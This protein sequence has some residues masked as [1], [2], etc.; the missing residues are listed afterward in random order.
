MVHD[1]SLAMSTLRFASAISTSAASP[2]AFREVVDAITAGLGGQ[3]PDLAA[4]FVSH[5]HGA[6]IEDL[7]P[8]LAKALN[9]RVLIGCTGESIV[10]G[11]RE[12]EDGAALS[13]WAGALPGTTVRP[14]AVAAEAESEATLRFEGM[15]VVRDPAR[16]SILVLADPYTFPAAEF[17]E[18][19]N[20]KLPGVPAIGGMASGG[21]GPGQ[22]LLFTHEGVVE[23]GA[24][25]VVLEG[26]VEIRP[27]VSQGCRPVG[28]PFVITHSRENFILKLGGRPAL[29]VLVE[30]AKA[31][32]PHDQKLLQ[33]GPFLGLAID[34]RKSAFERGDFLV[35]GIMGLDQGESAVVVADGT[36][37]NGMTVQFLV[38]DAESAGEDL[39]QLMRAKGG[40]ET[41][42][43]SS[44][45]AMVFSCNGR[46]SRMFSRPDHDI[47]CVQSGFGTPIPAAGFF[48][49]G[50]IG[51]VG[52]RNFLHGFTASIAVFRA[53]ST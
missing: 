43:P 19:L 31:L 38:R 12:V 5:H 35:R 1:P 6:A 4:V 46:G 30:V 7:G 52:G 42:A 48:A 23:G 40:G 2:T 26:E 28:K 47:G 17:L 3:R 10:G 18:I 51:P 50:E 21:S 9:A 45:G 34:A 53:R 20:E 49:A 16:A 24:I 25:G 14:Y 29:E 37:R 41:G 13:V 33:R 11:G 44:V 39:K 22:N 36:I 32:S 15:P 8:R 27:V